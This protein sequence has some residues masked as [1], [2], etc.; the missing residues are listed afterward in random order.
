MAKHGERSDLENMVDGIADR[1]TRG[2]IYRPDDMLEDDEPSAY[3]WLE[4]ALDIEYVVTSKGE[5]LGARVLVAFGGPN[6]WVNTRTKKVEGAWWSDAYSASFSD[7]I[8]LDDAL[9]EL[10]ECR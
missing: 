2:V 10:W 8:G 5:Y 4:D 6:I 3:D 9:S 7:E 1:I